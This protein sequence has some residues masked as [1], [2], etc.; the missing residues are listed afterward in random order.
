M[1]YTANNQAYLKDLLLRTPGS[2]IK[3]YALLRYDSYRDFAENFERTQIDADIENSHVQVRTYWR[4]HRNYAHNLHFQSND[5]WFINL[6]GNGTLQSMHIRDLQFDGLKNTQINAS[7]TLAASS[8]PT[9]TGARLT[10]KRLHTS[11]AD[12][13]L[14]TGRRLSNEQVNLPEE[15]NA[16]GTLAGSINNL[17]A[18][19]AIATSM[20]AVSVNGGLQTLAILMLLHTPHW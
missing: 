18:N 19:L 16:H 2:E 9:R 5:T 10:I 20:G 14:F 11:Q 12:I 15:F 6:Q 8:D 1:F 7:G 3:R 17:A 4:L 13:A